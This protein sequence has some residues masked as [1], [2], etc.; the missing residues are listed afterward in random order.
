MVAGQAFAA[1]D[2]GQEAVVHYRRALE[3]FAACGAGKLAANAASEL[4]SLGVRTAGKRGMRG[5]T[6]IRSLSGRERE[7]AGL[8]ADGLTN[9]QIAERLF[10]SPRT[11]ESHLGRI[12]AKLDA[13]TRVD[14]SAMMRRNRVATQFAQAVESTSEMP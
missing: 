13:P 5:S 8:V 12:F 7:V 9:P 6:G 11:V 3:A 14:V 4:R 10:L 1:T 2:R